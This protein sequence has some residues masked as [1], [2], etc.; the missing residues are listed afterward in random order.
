MALTGKQFQK[1]SKG[2]LSGFS[3]AD[4]EQLVRFELNERLDNIVASGA[5]AEVVFEL[6]TWG[7]QH[8]RT[9]ELIS[10]LQRAR[11]GNK[12]IQ[13]IANELLQPAAQTRAPAGLAPLDGPRR[14]RLR[15]AIEQQ[16]PTRPQLKMLVDDT[17]SANLDKI[18]SPSANL[19]ETV[20]ELI[21]WMSIDPQANLRPLLEEA[22]RQRPNSVEL[23]A[24]K[25]ELFGN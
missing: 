4:L 5:L 10:A 2:I 9:E 16:F 21:Q 24:I 1:L 12:E 6:V 18:V 23:G 7:E 11:P 3:G 19:T 17:L 14:A 20:F 25:Q 8:G 15:S 22:V 13:S